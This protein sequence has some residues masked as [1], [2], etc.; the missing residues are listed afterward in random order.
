MSQPEGGR[1]D[2]WKEI[3]GYLGRDLRTVR[4]WEKEKGLP[5]RRVPGGERSA[6]FAYSEEI[7]EWLQSGRV[8]LPGT[9]QVAN[10]GRLAWQ[11]KSETS[12]PLGPSHRTIIPGIA[13]LIVLGAVLGFSMLAGRGGDNGRRDTP[14]TNVVEA[15]AGTDP[16][17][18]AV[19]AI[20]PA[21][22]Q[23]IVIMGRGFGSHVAFTNQDTPYL[24][25]RDNTARWAAGRIIPTNWDEVTLNVASWTNSEIVVTRFS[26]AYGTR[27]WKLSVGD[28]VE[29]AIWNPQTHAGPGVYRLHVSTEQSL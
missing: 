23:R 14:G 4:R 21:P 3:A 19:T 18:T 29:I 2:S 16:V 15:S 25:I 10:E 28:E 12:T 20:G 8:E 27:G 9:S 1:L 11:I 17:I 13:L 24:A 6:V 22:D 26:G 5:V 7:D